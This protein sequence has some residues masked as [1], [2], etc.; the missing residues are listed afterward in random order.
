PSAAARVRRGGPRG[1]GRGHPVGRARAQGAPRRASQVR[2]HRLGRP[3]LRAAR[4]RPR[5]AGSV[6]RSRAAAVLGRAPPPHAGR[7]TPA[8][9]PAARRGLQERALPHRLR[10]RLAR[11]SA[12]VRRLGPGRN[13]RSAS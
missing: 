1:R 4:H 7:R 2:G 13:T 8:R 6:Q 11:I 5:A 10:R 9:G 3:G 12:P